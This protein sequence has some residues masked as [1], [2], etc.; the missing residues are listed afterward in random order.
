MLMDPLTWLETQ[1][2]NMQY[3]TEYVHGSM[4]NTHGS[5]NSAHGSTNNAHGSGLIML[6]VPQKMLMVP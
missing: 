1:P 5:T 3:Y 4:N 6:I 2:T